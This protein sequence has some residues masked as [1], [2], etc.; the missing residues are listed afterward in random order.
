MASHYRFRRYEPEGD[1]FRVRDF[2]SATYLTHDPLLNWGIE[3]WNW[4]RYHPSIFDGDVDANIRA[5]EG[6][7]GLWETETGDLAGVVHGED[8]R[9][10]DAFI[11]RHPEHPDLLEAMLDYAEGTLRDPATGVLRVYA[12]DHDAALREILARRGYTPD[13]EHPGYDSEYPIDTIGIP[14]PRLEDG[15]RVRSMAD[16]GDRARR[17]KAGGLGFNHPDPAEWTTPDQYRQ[18]QQAPDYRADLDLYVVG[19]D[20]EFVSS[21]IAWIDAPNRIGFFE[22]V[23]TN[24]HYRRRGFGREVVL[25]GVRRL[26]ALGATRARVGSGQPFYLAI[27]F[28]KIAVGCQWTLTPTG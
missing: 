7:V 26:A 28:R 8:P 25:E 12:Y 11:E 18:V 6:A 24:M 1:W 16:G 5:W 3:R 10:G 27:G 4:S 17:C 9:P 21:C 20:G 14:E 19:P 2:L 22:P 15:F 13:A 23:S